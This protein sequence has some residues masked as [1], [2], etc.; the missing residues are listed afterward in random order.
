MIRELGVDPIVHRSG[1]IC[2]CRGQY[3]WVTGR[4]DGKVGGRRTEREEKEGR[5]PLQARCLALKGA[6]LIRAKSSVRT[7]RHCHSSEVTAHALTRA[8][9]RRKKK[10]LA[11]ETG[12]RARR[13]RSHAHHRLERR[14]RAHHLIEKSTARA[15]QR[16][17]RAPAPSSYERATQKRDSA[18]LS[19]WMTTGRGR[20][21]SMGG[22]GSVPVLGSKPPND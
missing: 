4:R 1:A 6:S 13:P 19:S 16:C 5:A 22:K 12:K 17:K 15:R 18:L 11:F 14:A 21:T 7:L 8:R 20:S 9:K 2:C 3:A 10:A